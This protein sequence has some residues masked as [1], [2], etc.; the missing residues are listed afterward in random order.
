MMKHRILHLIQD[1]NL[2]SS[3]LEATHEDEAS[4]VC[5]SCS[6]ELSDIVTNCNERVAVDD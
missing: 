1:L 4:D 5:D 6:M 3:D 2:I